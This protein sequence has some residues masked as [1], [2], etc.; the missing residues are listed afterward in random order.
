MITKINNRWCIVDEEGNIKCY[1]KK[2]F[3]V[4]IGVAFI[5]TLLTLS[6]LG[7]LTEGS[8]L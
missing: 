6:S 3:F 8:L 4:I 1:L 7:L 2:R 5:V